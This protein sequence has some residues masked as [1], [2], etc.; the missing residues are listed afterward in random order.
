MKELSPIAEAAW[1]IAANEAAFTNHANI[2]KEHLLIAVLS[3]E[4]IFL[5]PKKDAAGP[6]AG[7]ML[8]FEKKAIDAIFGSF[9][10][11]TVT[12]RRRIR[13]KLGDGNYKHEKKIIHRSAGCKE[14][15]EH[16]EAFAGKYFEVSCIHILAA[17][18]DRPGKIISETFEE[19][20]IT[21][22]KVLEAV[23]S[24]IE[25]GS[26]FF[27]KFEKV[28][29]E[30][31]KIE[32]KRENESAATPTLD[33]Y[34]RDLT[35]EAR[36]G[37]IGPFIGRR[38]ELLQLI[39]ILARNLKNNPVVVG[40]AGCGKTA[41]VEALA[42]R[43]AEGKDPHIL[44]GKRIIEINIGSLISGTKYRGEFEEKIE[45]MIREASAHP[46]IILFIDEIHNLVGAGRVEGSSIDAANLLKPA[47]AN[48]SIRCIGAT[49]LDEF[50]RYFESDT[51][52]ER[53][54]EKV[55][56]NPSSP[57]ETI[58]ILKGLIKKFEKHHNITITEEAINAAVE[59]SDKFDA[60][61]NFPDKA[62]DLL[63]KTCASANIPELS[64]MG[65]G[66]SVNSPDEARK[67][68][69]FKNK[70]T[71]I[72]ESDIAR[73]LSN[74]IKI[75]LD[76]V[77]GH[78]EKG[79]NSRIL[80]LQDFLSSRIKGQ[81]EAIDAVC[82]RILMSHAGLGKKSGPLAVFMFLGPT[83]VG[84]TEL[85][86]SM[87]EF[88]FGSR[89]NIIRL[90]MSEFMEEHS[91]SK[92]TG[93]PPGYIGHG[94]E[95]QL[96]GKLR[97][98]PYSVV[99]LDEIEKAHPRVFDIF[100]QLFDEGRI[101]DSKG[102][103]ADAKNAIFIMTSNIAPANQTTSAGTGNEKGLLIREVTKKFRPEF[104]NRINEMIFFKKLGEEDV[105]EILRPILNSIIEN[106]RNQYGAV[107]RFDKMSERVIANSGYSE[108]YGVRELRRTVERMVEAPISRLIL[109]GR[110]ARGSSWKVSCADEYLSIV[111][112]A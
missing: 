89:S 67:S 10:L 15:F 32:P 108:E 51:A 58:E 65:P 105:I 39:Q 9:R 62:I 101:T 68:D 80:K 16:A 72:G 33:Y 6:A 74:K 57:A 77:R 94:E 109:N 44:G 2:E 50:R 98:A 47:L 79:H 71:V 37:K 103:T 102:K 84:K 99:L 42:V 8:E 31:I 11:Q 97:N 60:D 20:Y 12:L 29:S 85:A 4:K 106:L 87:A 1:N 52:L 41:M 70:N 93:P 43:T 18:L 100:L 36:E 81:D 14:S 49:T 46:E 23:I 91:V 107:L 48:G 56:L 19:A 86:S 25:G 28:K 110:M 34:G 26:E 73:T 83:G 27:K 78:F 54:F 22:A 55:I 24:S 30:N 111:P 69:G 96:T 61:H 35:R 92:L 88:L 13:E 82:Q 21:T 95:G 7:E 75:P 112:D 64:M 76:I 59:L 45:R 38:N 3:L 5:D 66:Q 90:D 53:R 17:I 63:D 104:I 40:P